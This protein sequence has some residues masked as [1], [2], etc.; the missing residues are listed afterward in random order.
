MVLVKLKCSLRR[1][2][3]LSNIKQNLQT[4]WLELS[5]ILLKFLNA[6]VQLLL[7]SWQYEKCKAAMFNERLQGMLF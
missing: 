7:T 5:W 3:S 2:N 6:S 4:L 1:E